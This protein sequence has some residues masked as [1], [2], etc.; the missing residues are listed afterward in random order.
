VGRSTIE[1]PLVPVLFEMR[2]VVFSKTFQLLHQHR[3]VLGPK[4]FLI[5]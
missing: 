2:G 1:L 3:K 5:L 4:F